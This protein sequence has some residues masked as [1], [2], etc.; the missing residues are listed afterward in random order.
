MGYVDLRH[1]DDEEVHKLI[2]RKLYGEDADIFDA[3]EL[4]WRGELVEF[5][6]TEVASFWPKKLKEAQELTTYLITRRVRRIRYGDEH[7]HRLAD[8]NRAATVLR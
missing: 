2:L 5:R 8:T 1:T 7:S 4:T 3:E 6:G